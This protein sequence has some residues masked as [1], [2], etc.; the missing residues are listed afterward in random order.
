MYILTFLNGLRA[1]LLNL[2]FA[3]LGALAALA[4]KVLQTQAL[5]FNLRRQSLRFLGRVVILFCVTLLRPR[6]THDP[7]ED[8][9][10]IL[11]R[12]GRAQLLFER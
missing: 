5:E 7:L 6:Q 1:E 2:S 10:G 8:I 9:Q 3:S 11:Q 4:C 12:E